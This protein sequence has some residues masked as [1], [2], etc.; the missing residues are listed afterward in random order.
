MKLAALPSTAPH[1]GRPE[2]EGLTIAVLVWQPVV[3]AVPVLEVQVPLAA[4]LLAE[5]SQRVGA[6]LGAAQLEVVGQARA[7]AAPVGR[8]EGRSSPELH[9]WDWG[10]GEGVSGFQ[11]QGDSSTES[12]DHQPLRP[13]GIRHRR[14]G[15][16]LL[17]GVSPSSCHSNPR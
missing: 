10:L 15:F 14:V 5:V 17:Q 8:A 16:S 6:V 13:R 3:L 11:I 2:E 7:A 4:L 1:A 12:R 9:L